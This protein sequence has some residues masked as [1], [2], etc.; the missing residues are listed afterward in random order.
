MYV[1][2]ILHTYIRTYVGYRDAQCGW[3]LVEEEECK[4]PD[5]TSPKTAQCLCIYASRRGIL[6]VP[7]VLVLEPGMQVSICMYVRRCG[8]LCMA[9]E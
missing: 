8:Q 9:E 7:T 6:E 2:H 1:S 3:L 4:A 5:T